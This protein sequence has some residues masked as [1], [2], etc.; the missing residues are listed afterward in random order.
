[1]R[2]LLYY[3]HWWRVWEHFGSNSTFFWNQYSLDYAGTR[4]NVLCSSVP[5]KTLTSPETWLSSSCGPQRHFDSSGEHK[6]NAHMSHWKHFPLRL[7]SEQQ[8][9]RERRSPSQR[10]PAFQNSL[11][12]NLEA[13]L[14][15]EK[16]QKPNIQVG[17]CSS[18]PVHTHM[19]V[20][21][22][23]HVHTLHTEGSFHEALG[24]ALVRVFEGDDIFSVWDFFYL[25]VCYLCFW[26]CNCVQ[27]RCGV[28]SCFHLPAPTACTAAFGHAP[29]SGHF[30]DIFQRACTWEHKG[31]SQFLQTFSW[32]F[33]ASPKTQSFAHC[34]LLKYFLPSIT[35]V[36]LHRVK[37]GNMCICCTVLTPSVH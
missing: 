8:C 9:L 6:C 12:G 19:H 11:P 15:R 23:L 32:T 18:L 35:N 2:T 30:P 27:S 28:T 10:G 33:P 34:L 25:F 14:A 5:R 29:K 20:H 26:D 13:A 21:T 17:H 7:W 4:Q 1:M 36:Q 3:G 24:K 31:P 22:H 16:L 37:R